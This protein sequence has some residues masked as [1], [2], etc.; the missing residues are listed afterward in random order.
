MSCTRLQNF[1]AAD[2]ANRFVRVRKMMT[3]VA[4]ADRAEQRIRNRVGEN[5]RIGMS[6]ESARVRNLDAAE[7]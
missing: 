3:D 2:S 7:N 1:D 5:I 6:F 4:F